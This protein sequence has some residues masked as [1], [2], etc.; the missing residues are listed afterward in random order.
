MEDLN[1]P[2]VQ[3]YSRDIG[4]RYGLELKFLDFIEATDRP[5]C[6]RYRVEDVEMA[7]T[8][9]VP[10]KFDVAYPLWSTNGDHTLLLVSNEEIWFGKGWH[11]H[12]AMEMI[13]R[14]SQGLL[15]NLFIAVIESELSDDELQS[16]A[17][18]AGFRY[19][20]ETLTLVDTEHQ[21]WKEAVEQFIA[22]ID[23]QNC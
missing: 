9:Y 1:H 22:D 17:Q 19:L 14:T 15:V 3:P 13:S 5:R 2:K 12:P 6:F 21:N 4:V 20:K 8:C 16:A 23:A 10:D 11:D 18:F 7:W